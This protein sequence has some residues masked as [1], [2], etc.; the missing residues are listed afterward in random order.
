MTQDGL[1]G[2]HRRAGV[3]QQRGAGMAQLVR[4][5]GHAA[6]PAVGAQP[7][8]AVRGAERLVAVNED[9][10]R[11]RLGRAAHRQ[12]GCERLGGGL[13]ERNQAVLEPF[14]LL[15]AQPAPLPIDIRQAQAADLAGAQ[16]AV[17]HE[18]EPGLVQQTRAPDAPVGGSAI[19]LDSLL[20]R[21]AIVREVHRAAGCGPRR[22]NPPAASARR[23][24]GRALAG[25]YSRCLRASQLAVERFGADPSGQAPVQIGEPPFRVQIGQA[26]ERHLFGHPAQRK[27]E[28][29]EHGDGGFV[30]AGERPVA[31]AVGDEMADVFLQPGRQRAEVML[32]MDLFGRGRLVAAQVQVIGQFVQA[33]VVILAGGSGDGPVIDELPGSF[34]VGL[35]VDLPVGLVQKAQRLAHGDA[36]DLHGRGAV[37]GI[38]Q[39]VAETTVEA[40]VG[41]QPIIEGR[42]SRIE[43]VDACGG[44]GVVCGVSRSLSAS[45]QGQPLHDR[46]HRDLI[47]LLHLGV[48]DVQ[49]DL[50]GAQVGM[51][52]Q[53]LDGGDRHP[54]F[55]Q[56]AAE[57]VA[58]LVAG[59]PHPG[60]AAVDRQPVLDAGDG[61]A[62]AK[63]VEEDGFILDRGADRQPDL[64]RRQRLG[65]Q[66]DHAL[67]AALAVQPQPGQAAGGRL[68][69]QVVQRQVAHLAD[70]QAAAQH[71]QEHGPVAR[72]VD[73]G[74]QLF[75]VGVLDVAGQALALAD[76]MALGDDR[77][78]RRVVGL[79][80][81]EAVERAQRGQAAVDGGD[82]VS[83]LP[84]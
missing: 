31:L 68:Q 70:A 58:Q 2:Q 28:R 37:T 39:P 10:F 24:G 78:A 66:V 26:V 7:L 79:D 46:C 64:Q 67:P 53:A 48:G 36:I 65:R 15:D 6:A 38:E 14:G 17:Q 21:G 73:D 20:A 75:Q 61:Q 34:Q 56:M 45:F 16:A 82:G 23:P 43:L 84:G 77:V 54:G 32:P 35:G 12:V 63:A 30:A 55:G 41:G 50:G 62:A 42:D 40:A 22:G 83:L 59:D 47:I 51:A 19:G 13:A 1:H 60:R 3:E 81:Q 9:F 25:R 33:F 29:A 27:G 8:V 71:E 80:G 5:S 11:Q 72:A 18:Q 57:G 52:E 69:V 4:R 44:R 49:V 74:E 76:E